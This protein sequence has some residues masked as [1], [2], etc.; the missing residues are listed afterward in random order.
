MP[1]R[2]GVV[3]GKIGYMS[4]E[5]AGGHVVDRRSDIFTLGIVLWEAL[6]HRRLF[7]G[8]TDSETVASI[9]RCHVPPLSE[10]APDVPASLAAVTAR[11]LS[12]TPAGRFSTALEMQR[13]IEGALGEAGVLMGASEVAQVIG[14]LVPERVREHERW[15]RDGESPSASSSS[16]GPV[17]EATLTSVEAQLSTISRRRGSSARTWIGI[18]AAVVGAAVALTLLR[19][20]RTSHED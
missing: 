5:Q 20:R 1:T 14:H 16:R 12:A 2:A 6:A 17:P 4:P 15:L 7:E 9:L 19:A 8:V 18:G 3:K 10:V 11:A 13:A